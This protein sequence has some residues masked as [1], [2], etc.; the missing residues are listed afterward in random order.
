MCRRTLFCLMLVC[1]VLTALPLTAGEIRHRDYQISGPFEYKNISLFLIQGSDWVEKENLLTLQEAL[2]QKL[3]VVHETGSVSELLVENLCDQPIFIQAG[4]IVKGGRQD[5]V[6]RFDIV[7]RPNS[8]KMPLQAFC[9]E[10]GRWS[11]RADES[12]GYFESS[13]DAVAF[14]NIKLASK[15]SGS[16]SEVWSEINQEQEKLGKALGVSVQGDRSPTSLQLTQEHDEVKML[17]DAVVDS[18]ATIAADKEN[19]LGFAYA[20][21][22][23]LNSAD[24]YRSSELFRKL[25]P[26]LIRACAIEALSYDQEETAGGKVSL[27]EV[28]AWLDRVEEGDVSEQNIGDNIR[29]VTKERGRDIAFESYVMGSREKWVH[30]NLLRRD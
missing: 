25:W 15:I 14:K 4:D 26:K 8:G 13:E 30:K 2:Q 12:T 1:L 6:L 16:Q 24:I 18:L 21:N 5:R 23:K 27:D 3:V 17:S 28:A 9:V 10:S 29:L 22:G 11:Q 20:L 7:L 19:V